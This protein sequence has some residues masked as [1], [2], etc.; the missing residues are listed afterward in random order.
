M[1]TKAWQILLAIALVA[2][3]SAACGQDSYP[4][5]LEPGQAQCA[6]AGPDLAGLVAVPNPQ[7]LAPNPQPLAPSPQPLAP[8]PQPLAPPLT[9]SSWYFRV[10][11]FH[12]NERLDGAD[13]VN[14]YG[15]LPTLGYMH[16]SGP[17]R[18]RFELFGSQVLG[19]SVHYVGAA[20]F[21]DGSTE[22]LS[23]NTNL[24][25]IRGE[26][27]LLLEPEA[28]PRVSFVVGVGTRFWIRDLQDGSSSITQSPVLGYQE[29]W[30]TIY[31][32]VGLENRRT[33]SD[34]VEFYAAGRIGMTAI[35]YQRVSYF[36]VTLYP[37]LGFTGQLEAGLRG[38][39]LFAAGFFETFSWSQSGMRQD[40]LQPS[41]VMFTAGLKT[42]V[43]F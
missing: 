35:T 9:E 33:L 16:R 42:G 39:R 32:Y 21:D 18:F 5:V 26:Y 20:M 41:S 31:P 38:R 8:S 6:L 11:Y 36:D 15:V 28:W 25:G 22:P 2:V 24:L 17:E 14:E 29:T 23:S 13:F 43:C 34:A 40:T 1:I 3:P 37:K 19:P 7:F 4:P 30:W 12:W 10:D 27:D